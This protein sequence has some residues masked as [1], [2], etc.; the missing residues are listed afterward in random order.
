MTDPLKPSF[1]TSISVVPPIKAETPSQVGS[2]T[3]VDRMDKMDRAK[4]QPIIKF[5]LLCVEAKAI[6][7]RDPRAGGFSFVARPRALLQLLKDLGISSA[8][9]TA[10]KLQRAV[11]LGTQDSDVIA[12]WDDVPIIVRCSVV[13]DDIWVLPTQQIPE[14]KPIDRQQAG[15]LRMAAH[16]GM[17]SSLGDD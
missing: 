7:G 2:V 12:W 4:L 17:L 11:V 6:H 5:Q 14:S 16:N 8:L 3:G 1:P 15:R 13:N 9:T 10:L